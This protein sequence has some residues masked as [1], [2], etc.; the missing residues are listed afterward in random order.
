M[1]FTPAWAITSILLLGDSVSASYG[2]KQ[3]E[4]WV[5]LLN[6]KLKAQ[7]STYFIH[8]AS[9]SGETTG[10]GLSRLPEILATNKID[11]LIIELGG[12]DGLR[13]FSPKLIKNNLL[14]TITLAQA[15]NIEVTLMKIRITPNYGPRYNQMFEQVFIDVAAEKN[16]R[17]I[18]FFMEEIITQPNLMQADGIHPNK[19]AQPFIVEIVGKQ[20]KEILSDG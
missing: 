13:G 5:N 15:K 19:K 10:G 14:Q 12:N 11:H 3:N 20:L 1:T 18:P 2:M 9:I 4:G 17:L 7:K 6:N 8:N 16:I